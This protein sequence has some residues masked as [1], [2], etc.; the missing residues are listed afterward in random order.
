MQAGEGTAATFTITRAGGTLAEPVT[1]SVGVSESGAVIEGEAAG[2]ATIAANQTSVALTVATVDDAVGETDSV[3]TAE[4]ERH[5]GYV[6][7]S[8]SSAQ[9]TV[10]DDDPVVSVTAPEPVTE[11]ATAVFT[12]TRVGGVSRE[13]QASVSVLAMGDFVSDDFVSGDFVSG[14]FVFGR[15]R[16]GR[17]RLWATSSWATSSFGRLR[18]GRLRLGRLRLG[19]DSDLSDVRCGSCDVRRGG[20]DCESGDWY[21]R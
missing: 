9:V 15:L 16:L 6:R 13:L 11:G 1:V 4:I 12:F 3:V 20:C 5:S 8:A 2:S 21:A 10:T 18:L 17:L 19:D 7:G 14:D